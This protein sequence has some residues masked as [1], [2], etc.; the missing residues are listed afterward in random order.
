[1]AV[2]DAETAC[3]INA[4]VICAIVNGKMEAALE[5]IIPEV[6]FVVEIRVSASRES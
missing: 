4:F 1:M 5:W 2:S 3:R 6:P